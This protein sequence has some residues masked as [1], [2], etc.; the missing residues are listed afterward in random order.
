MT[1]FTLR[2]DEVVK[3]IIQRG[4]KNA[5]ALRKNPPISAFLTILAIALFTKSC[6]Q[7]RLMQGLMM[8]NLDAW[9]VTQS[10]TISREIGLVTI[11]AGD[12]GQ[13]FQRRSPL[14]AREVW[15]IIVAVARA[16]A[17]VIVVD[18]DTSDW[19]ADELPPGWLQE[20]S[21]ASTTGQAPTVLW[22]RPATHP[23]A[24]LVS[25]GRVV[26]QDAR[27][28]DRLGNTSVC[29]GVPEVLDNGGLIR[30]YSSRVH[31]G[32]NIVVPSL[33]GAAALAFN[34][35]GHAV[36][37]SWRETADVG[38]C[39]L[40]QREFNKKGDD[41]T[42]I[43]KSGSR[44]FVRFRSSQMTPLSGT[45]L[46]DKI[47]ILGGTF[48]EARDAYQ[49]PLGKRDGIELLATAI[50]SELHTPIPL[51]PWGG[52]FFVV[53]ILVGLFILLMGR[54]F[55]PGWRLPVVILVIPAAAIL[56]SYYLYNSGEDF[57]SFMPVLCGVLAHELVD[58]WRESA[59]LRREVKEL[60]ALTDTQDSLSRQITLTEQMG[61]K[62]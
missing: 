1:Q 51:E 40:L 54:V 52:L 43:L 50:D 36:D 7:T 57:S 44:R 26:G 33:A 53:D 18:L 22:A 16:G 15:K 28:I 47:A 19:K 11:D 39:R 23:E 42:E 20:L 38:N 8:A 30:S 25:L 5:G 29:W 31:I 27:L 34:A 6:E 56:A 13:T 48:P 14:D 4:H 55:S 62:A 49:T 58:D 17:T 59:K 41:D 46:L 24:G 45:P 3:R 32:N 21:A 37:R 9:L 2:I 10:P 35:A 61:D 12:Y 60:R